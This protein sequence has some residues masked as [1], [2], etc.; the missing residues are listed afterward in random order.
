[1]ID[2][3][4]KAAL[5]GLGFALV[6]KDKIE[7]FV[8]KA[9]IEA[10]L[11]EEDAKQLLDD[12]IE[13]SEKAKKDLE[14]KVDSGVKSALDKLNIATKKELKELEERVAKLE[15]RDSEQGNE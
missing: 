4:K 6:T 1:M 15:S 5:I 14:A 9:A 8:K 7:E 3:L 12:L 2:T 10:K 13:K 11:S